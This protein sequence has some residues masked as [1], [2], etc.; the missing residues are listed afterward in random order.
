MSSYLSSLSMKSHKYETA[1][2]FKNMSWEYMINNV[3]P[4]DIPSNIA[5][6]DEKSYNALSNPQK[7][8]LRRIIAWKKFKKENPSIE[9]NLVKERQKFINTNKGIISPEVH[10]VIDEETRKIMHEYE[11]ENRLRKLND[12]A[13]K[14]EPSM[15]TEYRIKNDLL[16]NAPITSLRPKG[17]TGGNRRR[18]KR[19]KQ[20]ASKRK[21]RKSRKSMKSRKSR[22]SK[23]RKSNMR[24]TTNIKRSYRRK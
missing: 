24:K 19:I 23:S 18:T 5:K 2:P 14:P 6:R 9:F 11:L 13:P 16:P 10:S 3:D 12:Q 21:S 1:S 4:K 17:L 8:A 20:S 15:V 22:K 7:A